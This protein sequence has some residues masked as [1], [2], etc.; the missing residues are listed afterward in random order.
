MLQKWKSNVH[1]SSDRSSS[2]YTCNVPDI[3]VASSAFG[4]LSKINIVS[5]PKLLTLDNMPATLEVGDQVP[6][7]AQTSSERRKDGGASPAA[8]GGPRNPLR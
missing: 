6:I 4:T 3:S 2:G 5:S 8:I 7:I 1:A